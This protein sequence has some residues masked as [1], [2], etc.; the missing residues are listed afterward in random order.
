MRIFNRKIKRDYQIL[1]KM[2]AGVVLT[3]GEVKSLKGGRGTL[4]EAYVRIKNGEAYLF[5][6]YIYPYQASGEAD[7]RRTRKLLLHKKQLLAW[8]N[9]MKQKKL[10]IMP[11]AW[12]NK[13]TKIKL[14]IAL[15]KGKR[16]F[17]RR[18]EAKEQDSLRDLE[19]ELADFA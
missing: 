2:E 19:Q 14:G 10:T 18:K 12:Y 7:A 16:E 8:E 1:E 9:Q 13:G 6:A 17:D 11:V 3:G 15:A 4:D 5:N